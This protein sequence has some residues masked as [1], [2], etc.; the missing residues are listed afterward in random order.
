MET[1]KS[2]GSAKGW[3]MRSLIHYYRPAATQGPVNSE[4]I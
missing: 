2:E 1:G 4:G 3:R